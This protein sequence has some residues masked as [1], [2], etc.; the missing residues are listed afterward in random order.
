MPLDLACSACAA[1]A[2]VSTR[3]PLL[4]MDP[5]CPSCR[6][7]DREAVAIKVIES[8][9][10]RGAWLL[11]KVARDHGA[12]EARLVREILPRVRTCLAIRYGGVG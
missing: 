3:V 10:V 4:T 1:A 5:V 11:A 2:N 6:W 7:I 12:E 8:G 9:A